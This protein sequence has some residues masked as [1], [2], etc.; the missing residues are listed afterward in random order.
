VGGP[1]IDVTQEV[2]IAD[3]R[4]GDGVRELSAE[5]LA[6]VPEHLEDA[7]EQPPTTAA[8]PG[9]P[10]RFARMAGSSIAARDASAWVTDFLNAGYY[11][12]PV[13]RREVDDLR[14]AFSIPTTF[15]YRKEHA[16][17]ALAEALNR[18]ATEQRLRLA[19][20]RAFH[21]A[22][23]SHRFDTERSGRGVLSREQLLEG[24]SALL[25]DWFPDAYADDSRRG[26]GIAFESP[27]ER[28]AYDP[29]RRMRLARLGRLTPESAPPERQTWH[30]YPPVEMP[31]STA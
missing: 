17:T 1:A 16:R 5:E 3:E 21:R 18:P 4:A 28:A 14:P 29:Q 13:D 20:L 27:G 8:S 24:A 30:T 26:W 12:H 10:L 11:R 7:P 6:A 2:T 15:W 9:G 23:G 31:R 22:F 25:G 19:D